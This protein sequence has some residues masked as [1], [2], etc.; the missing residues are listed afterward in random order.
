M[1]APD[2]AGGTTSSVSRS[3]GLLVRRIN[4]FETRV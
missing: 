2:Q 1:V 3:S 4:P